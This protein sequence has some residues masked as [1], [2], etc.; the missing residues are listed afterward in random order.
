MSAKL[1]DMKNQTAL[2]TGASG[3]L[4]FT[5]AFALAELDSNL[6]LTDIN[7]KELSKLKD[8]IM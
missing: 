8:K 5:H 4:G 1:F 2:I 7:D 6:I 3:F